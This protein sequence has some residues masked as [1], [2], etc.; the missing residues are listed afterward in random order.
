MTLKNNKVIQRYLR[1]SFETRRNARNTCKISSRERNLPNRW[2]AFKRYESSSIVTVNK[3]TGAVLV[4][5]NKRCSNLSLGRCSTKKFQTLKSLLV[6][7]EK[8]KKLLSPMKGDSV[9]KSVD[10]SLR[11]QIRLS[12]SISNKNQNIYTNKMVA[13]EIL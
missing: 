6:I 12:R 2:A 8:S 5:N 10:S 9:S 13:I 4:L 1:S 3:I 7:V 11:T